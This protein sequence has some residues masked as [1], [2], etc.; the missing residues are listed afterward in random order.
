MSRTTIADILKRNGID[1]A[2]ERGQ[3]TT[4]K[5]FL[6]SHWAVLAA[7]DFFTVEVWGLRGLV[8]FYVFFVIELSTR[9]IEIAGITA[10]PHEAWMIQIGR[11]L[12]DPVGGFWSDKKLLIIDRDS[13]YSA[14]FR[15]LLTQAGVEPVRLPPRS[16]NLN[17]YASYCTS[18]VRSGAT[19]RKQRRSES[20]RPNLLTGG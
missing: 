10:N 12:I 2:P 17:A 16:P 6:S 19:L 7:G 20:F 1:P 18:S 9:K 13:T 3:R 14:A 4:W 8:T 5:Q 11:N 15:N